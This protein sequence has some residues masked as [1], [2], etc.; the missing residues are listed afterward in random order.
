ML[1]PLDFHPAF[2]KTKAQRLTKHPGPVHRDLFT[3]HAH[4]A[5]AAL[6]V[7]IGIQSLQARPAIVSRDAGVADFPAGQAQVPFRVQHEIQVTD[8]AVTAGRQVV[9]PALAVNGHDV[10]RNVQG[11]PEGQFIGTDPQ[12]DAVFDIA[13]QAEPRRVPGLAVALQAEIGQVQVPV[14]FA[15][16]PPAKT[17]VEAADVEIRLFARYQCVQQVHFTVDPVAGPAR[18]AA[19]YLAAQ[20]ARQR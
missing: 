14:F 17:R 5:V 19:P 12:P 16:E 9:R 6:H 8:L 4:Q 7:D 15:A 13:R 2:G 18:P 11:R 3:G 20:P 1:S 10:T